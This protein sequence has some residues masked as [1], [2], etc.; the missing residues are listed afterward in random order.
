MPNSYHVTEPEA[1][2][3]HNREGRCRK[4]YGQG[5]P[6]VLPVLEDPQ[7]DGNVPAGAASEVLPV[8][9][10]P[11][12]MLSRFSQ[13]AE[14]LGLLKR[15]LEVCA[16][17][18]K[19]W[20]ENPHLRAGPGE[21]QILDMIE[22]FSTQEVIEI[23]AANPWI[24][25]LVDRLNV[26]CKSNTN[27]TNARIEQLTQ[28]MPD[29]PNALEVATSFVDMVKKNAKGE[30]FSREVQNALNHCKMIIEILRPSK[31]PN[32]TSTEPAPDGMVFEEH[33]F[34]FP[35]KTIPKGALRG[36]TDEPTFKRIIHLDEPPREAAIEFL[37]VLH[38]Y[39][40]VLQ[41]DALLE[42]YPAIDDLFKR[43]C[44]VRSN[45]R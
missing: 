5:P 32:N 6:E 16:K 10:D 25:K 31:R 20:A 18:E 30:N 34:S 35:W 26:V 45:K 40:P 39:V 33:P 41:G 38:R 27:F 22:S 24:R 29:S 17:V 11:A 12:T 9:E 28:L 1:Q 7:S 23:L 13:K 44:R 8:S 14:R 3:K 15:F 4:P 37:D 42:E 21:Q 2:R 19:I 36:L 43:C